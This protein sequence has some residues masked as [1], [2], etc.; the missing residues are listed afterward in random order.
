MDLISGGFIQADRKYRNGKHATY[1]KG[2]GYLEETIRKDA[3]YQSSETIE[4]KS[5]N[6]TASTKGG[7]LSEVIKKDPIYRK[8]DENKMDYKSIKKEKSRTKKKKNATG[9]KSGS[10]REFGK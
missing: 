10:F 9:N 2:N 8:A 3:S 1:S 7:Y 4:K 6:Q 5:R